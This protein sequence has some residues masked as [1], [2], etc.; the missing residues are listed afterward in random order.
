MFRK[1]LYI[2][3]I[4]KFFNDIVRFY[5]F[6]DWLILNIVFIFFGVVNF[7]ILGV[8]CL[9]WRVGDGKYCYM[10]FIFIFWYVNSFICL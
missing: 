8:F 9:F 2:C 7:E 10:I 6:F 4:F 5:V 1:L 3:L